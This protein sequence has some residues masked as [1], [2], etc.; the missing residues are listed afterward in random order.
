M[1]KPT[2]ATKPVLEVGVEYDR[3]SL[4]TSDLLRAKATMKYHGD[5]P[6]YMVIVDLGIPPGFTV[7]SGDFAEMVGKNGVQKF[8]VTSRQVTLYLGDVKP[9]DAKTFEYTLKPKYPIKA[10]S[11]ASVVYEYNTPENRG[12]SAPVELTVTEK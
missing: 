12:T 2:A 4:S 10:K 1:W 11:P 3:T 7:D 9:G 5:L 6:T 8:S